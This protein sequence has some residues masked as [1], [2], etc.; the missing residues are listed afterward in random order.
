MART[1]LRLSSDVVEGTDNGVFHALMLFRRHV[2]SN[3]YL[4]HNVASDSALSFPKCSDSFFAIDSVDS[5]VPYR[6]NATTVVFFVD[7]L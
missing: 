5:K 7:M 3:W 1:G 6:S 4:R 2:Y